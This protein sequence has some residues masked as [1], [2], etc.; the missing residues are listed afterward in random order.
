MCSMNF[1]STS[2]T[3]KRS[4]REENEEKQKR[5][6]ILVRTWYCLRDVLTVAAVLRFRVISVSVV[7]D[8][9]AA[10]GVFGC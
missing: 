8:S 9:L 7:Q 6:V 10:F 1:N 2:I 5:N 3:Y 4:R